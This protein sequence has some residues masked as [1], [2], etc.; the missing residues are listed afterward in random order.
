MK[1]IK[2]KFWSEVPKNFTGIVEC[3]NSKCW[4]KEGKF[5]REDG[6]AREFYDGIN[7]WYKDGNVHREDGP[8]KEWPSGYKEWYLK[9]QY[10][11]EISLKNYIV[12]DYY[13]GK[14]DLMWYKLLDKDKISEHP[15][16]PGLIV[17]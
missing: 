15:D 12:L 17:K 11:Y 13:K 8:A 3:E 6:P 9:D 14:Y 2:I 16:I 10:Y 7:L 4:F 1:T 5:H